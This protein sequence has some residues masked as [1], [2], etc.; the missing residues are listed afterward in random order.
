ME[1]EIKFCKTAD[2]VNIAYAVAGSGPPFVKVANWMNHLEYDSRSPV[3]NHLFAEIARDHQLI[4]YDER[5][6][7]LSDRNAA[8]LSLDALVADLESVVDSMGLDRFPLFAISQGGPVA[9]AYAFKHPDKVSHLIILGSFPAGWRKSSP[10]PEV[11]AKREAQRTLI[12]QGWGSKN[13]AFRQMWTTLCIPDGTAEAGDSFNELQRLSATAEE[14]SRIFDAI[15]DLDVRDLLPKIEVPV[16]IFHSRNDA[17]VPFEEGRKMAA[18]IQGSKFVPLESKNH[19]LLEHEPA[20]PKFVSELRS[21]IG[22]PSSGSAIEA[23]PAISRICP[24][25]NRRYNGK[26]LFY[27]L[28]DGTKLSDMPGEPDGDNQPTQILHTD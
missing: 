27:C 25:C 28:D 11:V 2:G 16:L 23:Q 26:D 5:C 17:L 8:D 24:T 22:R 1:Q 6:T 3:W 4:R 18:M 7:G 13:P 9:I 15:G 10:S 20:W 12:R 14:A 21:F 19:L